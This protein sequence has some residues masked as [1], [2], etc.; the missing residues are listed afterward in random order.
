VH[1]STYEYLLV[2]LYLHLQLPVAVTQ[3]LLGEFFMYVQS[4]WAMLLFCVI[5]L[6]FAQYTYTYTYGKGARLG[7][8]NDIWN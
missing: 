5:C 3:I 1:L 7:F 6:L 4:F 8:I 2:S